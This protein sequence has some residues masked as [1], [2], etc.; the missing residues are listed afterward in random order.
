MSET[1]QVELIKET[2]AL[3]NKLQLIDRNLA[4]VVY[5]AATALREGKDIFVAIDEL[6]E[7][8]SLAKHLEVLLCGPSQE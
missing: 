6:K 4:A 5:A 7:Q 8:I 2:I 1:R 3:S